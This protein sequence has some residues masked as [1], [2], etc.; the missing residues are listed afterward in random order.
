VLIANPQ[1]LM[2]SNKGLKGLREA[3]NLVE[4]ALE[5]AIPSGKKIAVIHV[6]DVNMAVFHLTEA[7]RLCMK[8]LHYQKT[9]VKERKRIYNRNRNKEIK[10]REAGRKAGHLAIEDG[11]LALED[12]R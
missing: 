11:Q 4:T 7:L 1:L 9:V 3:A 2:A 12:Q 5:K 10:T 6:K 8:P